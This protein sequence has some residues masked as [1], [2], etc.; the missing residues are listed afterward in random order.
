M[1]YKRKWN[2]KNLYYAGNPNDYARIVFR[3]YG[4]DGS[5]PV[6]R[7][8]TLLNWISVLL[9]ISQKISLQFRGGQAPNLDNSNTLCCSALRCHQFSFQFHFKGDNFW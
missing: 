8:H 4:R 2:E 7:G 6:K 5:Y 1:E 3:R 9:L